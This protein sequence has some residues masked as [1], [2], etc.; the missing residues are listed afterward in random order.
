MKPQFSSVWY[1]LQTP[2]LPPTLT[3]SPTM[4]TPKDHQSA[5]VL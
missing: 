2:P 1:M 5:A 4:R 3:V